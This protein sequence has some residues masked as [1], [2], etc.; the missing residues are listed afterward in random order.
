MSSN[1]ISSSQHKKMQQLKSKPLSKRGKYKINS[2]SYLKLNKNSKIN[3]K[4]MMMMMD[5]L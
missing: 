5:G 1:K 3:S 2:K 4:I